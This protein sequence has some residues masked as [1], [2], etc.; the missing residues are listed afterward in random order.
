MNS[1]MQVGHYHC[2]FGSLS[3]SPNQTGNYTQRSNCTP[4]GTMQWPTSL[5]YD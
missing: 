5:Q 2:P 3:P 1:E 4:G